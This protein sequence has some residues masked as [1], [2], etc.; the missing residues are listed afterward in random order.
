MTI[1]VVFLPRDL[2]PADTADRTIVVLDVLRFTTTLTIAL[3]TG[4]TA[5]RPFETLD[6]AKRARA[7]FTA[8][9]LLCGEL[10]AVRPENFD[11]GNDPHEYLDGPA[12]GKTLFFA[13]TNGTRAV[14]AALAAAPAQILAGAIVNAQ[15]V[16]NQLAADNR[17]A[18]LLCSG[19]AG[20]FS[21]EDTL[22]AGAILHHLAT[23]TNVTNR[24][25]RA[26]AALAVFHGV[27]DPLA[28]MQSTQAAHNLARAHLEDGINVA[29]RLNSFTHVPRLQTTSCPHFT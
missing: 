8:P 15:A 11:L 18:T 12:R 20:Q 26:A 6:A 24:S 28:F 13:T 3:A 25:D 2:T 4:A 21:A 22:G 1:D 17:D 5:I 7:A 10:N 14:M 29:A 19:T 27:H 23:L 16:A 9:A